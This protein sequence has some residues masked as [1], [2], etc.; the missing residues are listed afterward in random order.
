[1]RIDT[2]TV[3]LCSFISFL[4]SLLKSCVSGSWI[5]VSPLR[6]LSDFSVSAC[7]IPLEG[8]TDLTCLLKSALSI[9]LQHHVSVCRAVV[10]VTLPVEI[11]AE[12]A[13]GEAE[14]LPHLGMRNRLYLV[15]ERLQ[16]DAQHVCRFPGTKVFLL[17]HP[18]LLHEGEK[19]LGDHSCFS[20]VHGSILLRGE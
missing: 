17:E 8:L 2:R 3:G 5:F 4:Y 6:F 15:V 12:R 7:Q 20:S 19:L 1:M 10:M 9:R 14:P 13:V 11:L 18:A 16:G